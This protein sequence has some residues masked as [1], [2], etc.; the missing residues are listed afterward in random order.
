MIPYKVSWLPYIFGVAALVW[1]WGLVSPNSR[2]KKALAKQQVATLTSATPVAEP[3]ER[4]KP[5][6]DAASVAVIVGTIVLALASPNGSPFGR[7]L[8]LEN[9]RWA[10][11]VPSIVALIAGG[12]ATLC[13]VFGY[14]MRRAVTKIAIGYSIGAVI[15]F[16]VPMYIRLSGFFA[17]YHALQ[18]VAFVLLIVA[19]TTLAVMASREPDPN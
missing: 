14:G 8:F 13:V 9:N 17:D 3:R 11:L 18:Q 16:A 19:C 12:V 15:A 1:I 7:Q 6:W 5:I 4:I 2:R 10:G